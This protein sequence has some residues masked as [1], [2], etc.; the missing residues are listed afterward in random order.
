MLNMTEGN[1]TSLIIRFSIPMLIGNIFQ[2]LY[3]LV[4]SVIVGQFVGP[5][6]LA[7]IGATT[8]VTFLFIAL[9]NGIGSGGGIITSQSFGKGDRQEVK[10][11]IINTAFIMMIFPMVIGV[12]AF[13]LSSPLLTLLGTPEGIM[14]DSLGYMRTMCVGI[15][16]VSL[17]NFA[18]SMLRALGDSKTPLYF[19]IFSCLLNT[20]LDI[21]FVYGLEMSVMGAGIATVIA[22]LV[23]GVSCLLYAIKKNEYFK[24]EKSEIRFNKSIS[25]RI[26]KL[27]VPLS[28]QFSLISISCMAL[29][30]VV[31]SFGATAMAAFTATSRMEQLIHQP[32]Q[33]LG[34][35]LSTF[36]GQNYGA[37]K[38]DRVVMGYR[39]G[40]FIMVVFSL[41][42]L[43]IMQFFG[44]NIIRIFVSDAPVVEMGAKALR[45]TSLFYVCLG[46]IYVVRGVLN[47]LG[48]AFF[49][50]LNGIV[51]VIGRFTVPIILT[52]IAGI[53]VW[54]IWWSVGI[55][56][57]LAGG[58]ALFRYISYKK[59]LGIRNEHASERKFITA[60]PC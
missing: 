54:G 44:D 4:D 58:S 55:V 50:L 2:Q 19:L 21:L 13:L 27:G 37:G 3:N 51:E 41:I 18:S 6:A 15:V 36:T 29:Q 7:A 28:L 14:E 38:N 11:C 35:A 43:P 52:G 46:T 25:L 49:A 17:Y 42:M 60:K 22:Q 24:M 47:G 5:N 57:T 12:I 1:P 26:V 23:S 10:A 59:K 8:S 34:T 16:F 48:D 45:I 31:N 40:T 32:Y 56:W 30:R 33:T 39:K 9:C 20:G 53:G